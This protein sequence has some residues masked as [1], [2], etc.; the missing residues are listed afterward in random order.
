MGPVLLSLKVEMVGGQE[1]IRLLLRLRSATLH[2]LLPPS[3]LT[4]H[5]SPIALA[6]VSL[7]H[8]TPFIFDV[9][10][11]YALELYEMDNIAQLII[12]WLEDNSIMLREVKLD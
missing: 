5:P 10:L 6:K 11:I 12:V 1:H 2:E 9:G 4:A 8:F 7:E 3:C